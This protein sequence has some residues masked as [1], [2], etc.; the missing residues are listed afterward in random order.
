MQLRS[1]GLVLVLL[2]VALL[3]QQGYF[4]SGIDLAQ[5]QTLFINT[6]RSAGITHNRQGIK[7]AVGQAWGDYDN[8]GWVDLYVTDSEGLNILYLNNQNGTF[9]V[10][11]LS[12]ILALPVLSRLQS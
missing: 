1:L 7:K 9:S 5:P 4:T 6:S 3:M 11:Q 2:I 12:G 8:D 10:S